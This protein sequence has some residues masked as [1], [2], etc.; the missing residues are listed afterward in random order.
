MFSIIDFVASGSDEVNR[1]PRIKLN[2]KLYTS[3]KINLKFRDR[4][5]DRIFK[6]IVGSFLLFL[7]AEKTICLSGGGFRQTSIYAAAAVSASMLNGKLSQ[8]IGDEQIQARFSRTIY[9]EASITRRAF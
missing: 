7:Q 5:H 9:R 3:T 1:Y 2:W 6:E 4:S 8:F